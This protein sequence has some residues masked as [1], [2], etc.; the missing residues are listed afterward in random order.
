MRYSA[1][2]CIFVVTSILE[3]IGQ[4]AE[5]AAAAGRTVRRGLQSGGEGHTSGP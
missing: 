1:E 3:S 2:L 5:A 4:A